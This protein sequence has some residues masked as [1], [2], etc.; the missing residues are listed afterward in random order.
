MEHKEFISRSER[1]RLEKH[2]KHSSEPSQGSRSRSRKHSRTKKHPATDWILALVVS[3]VLA[4][5]IRL[6]IFEPFHVSGPS[7]QKTMFSGDQVM[8]NKL[9]YQFR[10]PD[11][12]EVIVFHTKEE[13]DLI[14]RV[15]ALPGETVEVKNNRLY[16]NGK[17]ISEPYLPEGSKTED[18]KPVKVPAGQLFV[19]GDNRT[20]S[21]DSRTIGPIPIESVIGRASFVY[22]PFTDWNVL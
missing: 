17:E 22:W 15:I 14:K 18:F 6:F 3:V 10:Q 9:I 19:L 11:S 20:N 2:K 7:M 8:V 12:G 16:V 4:V 13:R 5:V 21:T 1:Q